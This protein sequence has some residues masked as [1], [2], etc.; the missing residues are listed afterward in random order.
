[1]YEMVKGAIRH[2]YEGARDFDEVVRSARAMEQEAIEHKEFRG[3]HSARTRAQYLPTTAE[4]NTAAPT[5]ITQVG[6]TELRK[7]IE[8][9]ERLE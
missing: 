8:R 9:V 3:Q 2:R 1:M 6:D 5:K 7:L 4:P